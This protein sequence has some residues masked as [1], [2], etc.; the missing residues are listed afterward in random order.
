MLEAQSGW[1]RLKKRVGTW[2]YAPLKLVQWE[3]LF[4]KL[5]LTLSKRINPCNKRIPSLTRLHYG[6]TDKNV[7]FSF[8]TK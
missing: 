2:E 6:L 3:T 5:R 7:I 8:Q 4:W 1:M